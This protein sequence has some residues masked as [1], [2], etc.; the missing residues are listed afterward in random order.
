VLDELIVENLGIIEKAQVKPGSGLVAFTGET[1]A[2]KTMLLGA[3]RLLVGGPARSD[4]IGPYGDEARVDGRFVR[5]D[6]E[7]LV[8][9][10]TVTAGRSRAYL[11]GNMATAGA[12]EKL[13]SGMVEMVA[14]HEKHG[15][16]RPNEVRALIDRALPKTG[17][18]LL[19][20]YR[21]AW[22]VLAGLRAERD[23][24][25][26]DRRAL[27][28]ELDLVGYQADEIRAAG[29]V[30]GEDELL[31]TAAVRMRHAEELATR[32]GEARGAI[33]KASD[34]VGGAAFQLQKAADLD[35]TLRSLT[36]QSANV[37]AGLAELTSDLRVAF[38]LVGTDPETAEAT[39]RRLAQLGDLRRKYGDSLD[40]VLEFGEGAGR[41]RDELAALLAGA[42]QLELKLNQ[43]EETV[44]SIGARVR[45]VRQRTA[46]LIAGEAEQHLREL[47]IP[48]PIVR[49]IV[50]PADPGPAG[51]DVGRLLFAS[52]DR[53]DP[54]PVGRVASGGELSRLVLALRLASGSGSVPIV[55]FDEIDAG[56]GGKTAL[57][58]GRKLASLARDRQ[59]LCVTHL[60][61]VAAFADRHF[62]ITRTGTTVKVELVEQDGRLEELSRMLA[63]LPDSRQGR[64]H[65][66]ELITLAARERAQ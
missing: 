55:A 59:V 4:I 5:K 66:D 33:E 51:A 13:G 46:D 61:Q 17:A 54:A 64:D 50:E 6:G 44:A 15:L 63:G 57:E 14:Q 26:G 60:P 45:D 38:E 28:R 16:G 24:L 58:L 35:R 29:F 12:L 11:N 37:L 47:G 9:A 43:A 53:L 21:L 34:E 48:A 22:D 18:E 30:P 62:V 36:D 19:G 7:E 65:A 41:R 39:E 25:G 42:E 49:L 2:G 27:E 40:E 10:R 23:R 52:D 3:L 56:V 31:A 1:G 8:V 20:E 32:L